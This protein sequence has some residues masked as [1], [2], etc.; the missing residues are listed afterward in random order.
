MS[1]VK[2]SKPPGPFEV[3]DRASVEAIKDSTALA[4]WVFLRCKPEGWV[5][6]ETHVREQFGIGRDKYRSA[7]RYLIGLGAVEDRRVQGDHGRIVGRELVIHYAVTSTDGDSVNR[8]PE[9]PAHGISNDKGS[10]RK[11]E[12]TAHG[13]DRA[14]EKPVRRRKPT[15][16]ESAPLENSNYLENTD[17]LEKT[18]GPTGP[19]SLDFAIAPPSR[20]V[21]PCPH[22]A[23]I[24][25]YLD[26]LPELRGVVASR[27]GESKDAKALATRWR[28]DKRHQSLDFWRRFFGTVR[29]NPHWM[30]SNDRGWAAD[31]R[32]LVKRENFDKVIDRMVFDREAA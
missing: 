24:E 28:E 14:P 32:W 30:G 1:V 22:R 29:T 4:M 6:R 19:L 5:V 17:E 11:P 2:V 10:D 21:P 8:A 15:D 20:L 25:L 9:N 12:N 23:I 3:I 18:L 27:W 26:M 31:L 7:L 16:G 13:A